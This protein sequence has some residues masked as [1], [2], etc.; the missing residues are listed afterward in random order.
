MENVNLL[1]SDARGVFIPRD[2]VEGFDLT[3]WEGI[4]HDDAEICKNPDHDWYWEAWETILSNAQYVHTD[5]RV[6][7]LY[8]D[9]DLWALCYDSM[10]EEEKRNFGIED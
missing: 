8:Q 5:G 1:L 6:F 10:S 2:F 3:K 4:K 9:G 7:H